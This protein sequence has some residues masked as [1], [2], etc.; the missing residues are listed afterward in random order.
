MRLAQSIFMR[1]LLALVLLFV[2]AE[3]ASAGTT[4]V[5]G[6]EFQTTSPT[7]QNGFIDVFG[8][9]YFILPGYP[10]TT[11]VAPVALPNAADITGF[12]VYYRDDDVDH[13]VECNLRRNTIVGDGGLNNVIASTFSTDNDQLDHSMTA[14]LLTFTTVDNTTYYYFIHASFAAG[15]DGQRRIYAVVIDYDDPIPTA[16][17]PSTSF[18]GHASAEPNPFASSTS[19]RFSLRKAGPVSIDIYDIKGRKVR[20][21]DKS[22]LEAG[23]QTLSWDGYDDNGRQV[24]SGVYF[25]QVKGQGQ[26]LAAKLVRVR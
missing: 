14:P 8:G 22:G 15:T 24:A 9:Y 17:T 5:S 16:T 1:T 25:A 3:L 6:A 2:G 23:M 19:I 12:T 26:A 11:A 18:L 13:G 10:A 21:I 20:T 4:I 7:L